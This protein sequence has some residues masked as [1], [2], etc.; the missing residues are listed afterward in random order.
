MALAAGFRTHWANGPRCLYPRPC[1]FCAVLG[2][3]AASPR[4]KCPQLSEE[5]R[6]GT[7]H[8]AMVRAKSI[9]AIPVG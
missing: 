6:A 5:L 3:S 7:M 2:Q 9:L 8:L 1:V 4:T